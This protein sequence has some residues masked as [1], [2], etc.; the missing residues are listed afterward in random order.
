[1]SSSATRRTPSPAHLGATLR[2]ILIAPNAG[3]AA[4]LRAAERRK[5]TN[6]TPTEGFT[7]YV[8]AAVGGIALVFGWL[9]LSGLAGLRAGSATTFRWSFLI[10]G[11]VIGA[12]L[13]L[14]AQFLWGYVG[15]R[16]AILEDKLGGSDF[17]LVWGVAAAPQLLVIFLLLPGD[18]L[19]AGPAAFTSQRLAD[20]V[21]SMWVALSAALTVACAIWSAFLL[22]KGLEALT[23]L[24]LSRRL[25]IAGTAVGCLAGVLVLFRFA[26]IAIAGTLA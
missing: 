6:T 21:T 15:P 13:A 20:P 14:G 18:L 7:P 8:L 23:E 4:A 19:I 25:A 9:K 3:F 12:L 5:K 22:L 10:A 2:S 17:R 24:P 1:V 26:A 16:T 11:A